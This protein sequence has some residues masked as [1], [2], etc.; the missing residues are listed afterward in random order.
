MWKSS[1]SWLTA[2]GWQD[3]A[4]QAGGS[5]CRDQTRLCQRGTR[6]G[7]VCPTHTG[8]A[9]ALTVRLTR[10]MLAFS[11]GPDGSQDLNSAQELT[12]EAARL[13]GTDCNCPAA[14]QAA[15]SS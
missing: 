10:E 11:F 2:E 13:E 6:P 5:A 4:A 9:G 3:P 12:G 8:T 14:S 1:K 7:C 15:V